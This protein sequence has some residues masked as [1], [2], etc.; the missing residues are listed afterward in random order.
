MVIKG[1]SRG[2]G[3][4]LA[5]YLM[6]KGENDAVQ[7]FEIRGTSQPDNIH[8]SLLE[9]S[10]TSE[11][12]RT[13][14]GLYHAQVCPAY[15]EDRQMTPDDWLKAVDILENVLKLNDQKRII[16][17]HEKKDR[18]HAHVVWE[19][20][21]HE[22]KAMRDDSYDWYKERNAR[23][24]I[25]TEL[26][27]KRTPSSN[28]RIPQMKKE[29]T[30]IWKSTKTS[31][32]FL[33]RAGEK[34]YTFAIGKERPYI[35]VDNTGRSFNLVRQIDKAKTKEI[36]ERLKDQK[37]PTEKEAITQVRERL[38]NPKSKADDALRR[39]KFLDQIRQI[40]EAKLNQNLDERTR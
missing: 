30:E 7:I 9:M 21:D 36:G 3:K 2:N 40:Q 18:L 22:R 1:K 28:E 16:V 32:D 35:V 29:L 4:Q 15:G 5:S 19:R 27:H 24:L 8:K 37:L 10:L 11:L 31:K 13:D 17:F 12:S 25:E 34:G 39:K 26:G 14:K 6:N 33:K 38:N 20:Y 23:A